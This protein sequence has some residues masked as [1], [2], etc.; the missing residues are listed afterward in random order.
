MVGMENERDKFP[1]QLSGG[2]KQK[3]A[4]IRSLVIEPKIMLMDEPMSNL[5]ITA[6]KKM[7]NELR[8]IQQKMQVTTIY[9]THSQSE[10]ILLADRVSVLNHGKIERIGTPDEVYFKRLKT[11]PDVP[12]ILAS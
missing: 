8:D 12:E 1:H 11:R 10:A 3:I 5:D 9:V 2:Q 4:L 7:G 6:R